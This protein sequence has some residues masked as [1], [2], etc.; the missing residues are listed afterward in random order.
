MQFRTVA[1]SLFSRL[2]TRKRRVYL[3]S[4]FADLEAHR[5]AVKMAL[6]P[7][8]LEVEA[9]ERYAAFDQRPLEKCLAD[10]RACDYYI[11]I[12]ARRYGFVPERD[13]AC[14]YSIT[15]LEYLEARKANK[16]IFAFL[17]D[18]SAN[19]SA[20]CT[21]PDVGSEAGR[22]VRFRQQVQASHGVSF[23]GSPDELAQQVLQALSARAAKAENR[24][25]VKLA[26]IAVLGVAAFLLLVGTE[27]SEETT[28][29]AAEWFQIVAVAQE[30]RLAQAVDG[31]D[32][33]QEA[34]ARR[35]ATYISTLASDFSAW[36]RFQGAYSIAVQVISKLAPKYGSRSLRADLLAGNVS[37]I[38]EKLSNSPTKTLR[39]AAERHFLIG[40]FL[41]IDG[42][43]SEALTSYERAV[44][45]EPL[46]TR[47][48]TA[49][50]NLATNIGEFKAA[51]AMAESQLRLM[52]RQKTDPDDL[53]TVLG[54]EALARW[55][56]GESSRAKVLFNEALS[57]AKS[58]SVKARLLNDRVPIYNEA[59]DSV[60][61]EHT[62]A[63]SAWLYNCSPTKERNGLIPA[64]LNLAASLTR[65]GRTAE[66]E[67]YLGKAEEQ[68][69]S[70][71]YL[72]N[73]FPVY[74]GQQ[75][76]VAGLLEYARNND[77]AAEKSFRNAVAIFSSLKLDKSFLSA[78]ARQ[79]LGRVLLSK[80]AFE[81]ATREL[82]V[83]VEENR[84]LFGQNHVETATAR[85]SLSEAYY[86][87]R[88]FKAARRE[89]DTAS[90]FIEQSKSK[91]W[92]F[93]GK[94]EMVKALLEL[95]NS[96]ESGLASATN[97]SSKGLTALEK[98]CRAIEAGGAAT[99]EAKDCWK[100]ALDLTPRDTEVHD[101]IQEALT[102][103]ETTL[104][105]GANLPTG[106]A[107]VWTRQCNNAS[108]VALH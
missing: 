73:P 108:D 64:L 26:A 60:G 5:R 69:R 35:D 103:I 27:L 78:R 24:R 23:F 31:A 85:V 88:N 39:D 52:E 21:D 91:T 57:L 54:Y 17:L 11:L 80:G 95:N 93:S 8:G 63:T 43:V 56:S 19:W 82:E 18:P 32:N 86:R 37:A 47:Y 68:F 104:Q 36:K 66:A 51:V 67:A 12:L 29:S 106:F 38:V 83:A 42:R 89:L 99:R 61:A 84:R 25:R 96:S 87:T 1:S 72:K 76:V 75:E 20:E 97:G 33:E 81:L 40:S 22:I 100:E 3:S 102:H 53:A 45:G 6:E 77:V 7:A 90:D 41:E 15:H 49:A 14:C 10:V 46:N 4:T 71:P 65:Q 94:Y 62:L 30:R 59:G 79:Y 70:E 58:K 92:R 101:R 55:F 98:G 28:V 50:L 44:A 48:S 107:G 16:P 13:N 2:L 105:G 74:R 9:M 34:E